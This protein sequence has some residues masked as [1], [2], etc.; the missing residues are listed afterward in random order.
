MAWSQAIPAIKEKKGI[1]PHDGVTQLGIGL[2]PLTLIRSK[3]EAGQWLEDP[4]RYRPPLQTATTIEK[5]ED[6]RR[7][8]T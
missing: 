1:R 5:E 4:S 2:P 8:S 3:R 6:Q 7:R